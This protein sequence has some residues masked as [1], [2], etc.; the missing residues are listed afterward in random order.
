MKSR[1]L[2]RSLARRDR[3]GATLATAAGAADNALPD[4]QL[5]LAPEIESPVRRA[6]AAPGT[7]VAPTA[8]AGP[9]A[10]DS[11]ARRQARGDAAARRRRAAHQRGRRTRRDFPACRP[12]RRR[13]E[14][15][16]RGIR[17]GRTALA[18]RDGAC[19]TGCV[20]ISSMTKS[21]ARATSRC[22]AE[23]TRSPVRSSSSSATPRPAISSRPS[24]TSEKSVPTAMPVKY[25]SWGPTTSRQARPAIRRAWRRTATGT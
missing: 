6:P 2:S 12:H 16:R 7:S 10:A 17:Q 3:L 13:S 18:P 25:G 14:R 21:G 24:I 5:K 19:R 23:S 9:A 15:K 1:S 8:H 20:T 11:S 22:A 4:P